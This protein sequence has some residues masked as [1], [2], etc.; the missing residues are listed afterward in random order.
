MVPTVIERTSLQ[1][2]PF[3][4]NFCH[5]QPKEGIEQTTYAKEETTQDE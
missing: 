3:T 2:G 4:T 5:P 1:E